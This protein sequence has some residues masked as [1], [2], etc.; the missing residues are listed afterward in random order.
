[1]GSPRSRRDFLQGRHAAEGS[2]SRESAGNSPLAMPEPPRNAELWY[3]S[4]RAMACTFE[5]CL[6]A[7]QHPEAT[8]VASE[9]LDLVEEMERQLSYFRDSSEL[10][11]INALAAKMPVPVEPRLFELLQVGQR[12]YRESDGAY[13]LTSA[14]LWELWGFARHEGSVPSQA[15]IDAAREKVGFDQ[16]VLE[17]EGRT[18]RFLREGVKLNFGSIGKGYAL[19]RCAELLAQRGVNDYLL[20]GGMSSVLAKGQPAPGDDQRWSVGIKNPLRLEKRLGQVFLR[21]RGLSTSGSYVQSFRFEGKRYG[22]ILDPRSGWPAQDVLSATVLAP[23]AAL[24]EALSTAMY[25]LGREKAVDY[26][27]RNPEV[28]LLM[29]CPSRRGGGIEIVVEGI[30]AHHIEIASVSP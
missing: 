3:I 8:E 11:R 15:E 16:V 4:R 19:D 26:C 28:G 21:D 1:M 27:R 29:L 14:P 17:R 5:I 20:S 25:V 24:A 9:A 12:I 2:E 6:S 30:A 22:H 18:V 23:T 10:T 13:D 7:A